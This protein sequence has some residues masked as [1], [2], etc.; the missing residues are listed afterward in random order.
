MNG[1]STILYKCEC[2][3]LFDDWETYAKGTLPSYGVEKKLLR[4]RNETEGL[5]STM[6]V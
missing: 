2:G 1:K 3:N 6:T 4:K 5:Y